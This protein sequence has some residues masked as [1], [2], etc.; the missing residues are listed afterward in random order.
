MLL[1]GIRDFIEA[2]IN[3]IKV[4]DNPEYREAGIKKGQAQAALQPFF[5]DTII[6]N[7]L[8]EEYDNAAYTQAIVEMDASYRQGFRDGIKSII[9]F[10]D[11]PIFEEESYRRNC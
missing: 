7:R 1:Q 2:R 5:T 8:L 11:V 10:A 9:R 3:E 4:Y 6:G